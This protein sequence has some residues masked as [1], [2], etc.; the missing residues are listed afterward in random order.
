MNVVTVINVDA[1]PFLAFS[2]LTC[3]LEDREMFSGCIVPRDSNKTELE[4]NDQQASPSAGKNIGV[5]LMSCRAWKCVPCP[6]CYFRWCGY[7]RGP[8]VSFTTTNESSMRVIK[9][10]SKI[11]VS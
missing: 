4:N 7:F 10:I 9:I 5:V 8:W 1:Y 2:D 6:C 11:G 3:H